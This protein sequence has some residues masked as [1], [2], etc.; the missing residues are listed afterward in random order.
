MATQS[1]RLKVQFFG[2]K[3]FNQIRAAKQHLVDITQTLHKL[4]YMRDITELLIID[5]SSNETTV[6]L[7]GKALPPED[8]TLI[9]DTLITIYEARKAKAKNEVLWLTG[10]LNGHP[11]KRA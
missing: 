1:K 3:K 6:E 5:P 7:I 4:R 11:P 2:I 10:K 8:M 9:K